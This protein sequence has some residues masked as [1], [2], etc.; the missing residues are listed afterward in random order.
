MIKYPLCTL[1]NGRTP[2]DEY[3]IAAQG[4][5]ILDA[6][7]TEIKDC[8]DYYEDA[9]NSASVHNLHPHG[10]VTHEKDHLKNLYK[11]SCNIA[12]KIRQH[13]N[14]FTK[15][16]KSVY[17][18]KCPY[19]TLSE[20][21]TIEHILPRDTYPEYA[22]HLYNL[23]PCCSKCNSHKGSAV[24]DSNGLPHTINFYYHDPEFCQFLEVDCIIDSNGY[25]L[26]KYRLTFPQDADPIL[27]AIITNHFTRLHLIERYNEAAIVEYTPIELKIKGKSLNYALQCLQEDLFIRQKCYGIN[28][29]SIALLRCLIS[30]SEYHTYLQNFINP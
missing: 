17:H 12:K 4:N 25:P 5:T 29:Y 13:H 28:H 30:S 24:C 16:E 3:K 7:E 2:F 26:F 22:V 1:I 8:Y 14:S 9:V 19:C 15:K 18:N 23:I 27:A 11:S 21:N 10:F 6:I 20:P